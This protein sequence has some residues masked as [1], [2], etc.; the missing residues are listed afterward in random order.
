MCLT[1]IINITP[2][3]QLITPF[4]INDTTFY[5]N[6]DILYKFDNNNEKNNMIFLDEM[7]EIY[8][9]NVKEFVMFT[10]CKFFV[11]CVFI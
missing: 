4:V 2:N 10:K 5:K 3:K 8:K 6:N 11:A 9:Y 1:E 7:Y